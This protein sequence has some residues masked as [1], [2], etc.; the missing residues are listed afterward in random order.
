LQRPPKAPCMLLN[1]PSRR[2][3]RP[4]LINDVKY[5]INY[6]LDWKRR[7]MAS[8]VRECQRHSR[9]QIVPFTVLLCVC[10]C[11]CVSNAIWKAFVRY[12]CC[13]YTY[14]ST[15]TWRIKRC[16][17]LGV[18]TCTQCIDTG[19]RSLDTTVYSIQW[20]RWKICGEGTPFLAWA[21]SQGPSDADA[22][23]HPMP[24]LPATSNCRQLFCADVV[25]WSFTTQR[26]TWVWFHPWVGLGWM[27]S[28]VAL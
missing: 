7:I 19:A 12:N 14:D 16:I 1:R 10:V 20:L 15:N 4:L 9:V 5:N 8:H 13:H 23:E 11:V 17:L 27:R 18:I 22:S 6:C 2:M 3:N 25:I 28:T 24:Y 26:W 21:P